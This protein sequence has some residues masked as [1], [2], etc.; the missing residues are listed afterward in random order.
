[1][2]ASQI[3][4]DVR[5]SWSFRQDCSLLSVAEL[6]AQ[7]GATLGLGQTVVVAV[8]RTAAGVL[9]SQ[10]LQSLATM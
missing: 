2:G 9:D 1:M 8:T 5:M 4:N 3:A 7:D 10:F 6:L